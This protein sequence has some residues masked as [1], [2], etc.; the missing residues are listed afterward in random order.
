MVTAP[1]Y[2]LTLHKSYY[3]KGF[4]NVGVDVDRFVRPDSGP[5]S[6]QLGPSRAEIRGT[7]NRE[8]NTNG[9]P[10]IMGGAELRNWFHRACKELDV[11]DVAV[12]APD[13]LWIK[14]PRD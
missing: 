14:A 10:R 1:T 4:F 2:K 12:L 6:I 11:V 7:V 13:R 9:T 8:A 5:I 3:D